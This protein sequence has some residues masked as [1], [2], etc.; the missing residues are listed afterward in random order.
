MF[1]LNLIDDD[2]NTIRFEKF[3]GTR[4]SQLNITMVQRNLVYSLFPI[5]LGYIMV[6]NVQIVCNIDSNI[7][8]IDTKHRKTR[9][10][11]FVDY[12]VTKCMKSE[13]VFGSHSDLRLRLR[14]RGVVVQRARA[15]ARHTFDVLDYTNML[16]KE[17]TME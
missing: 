10:E 13:G 14:L 17:G 8:M 9:F 15:A 5:A 4:M 2:F 1:H 11:K 3:V 12:D 7:S 16:I 6:Q